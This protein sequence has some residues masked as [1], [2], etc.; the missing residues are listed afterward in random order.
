MLRIVAL[1]EE[2]CDIYN[3]NVF[4]K[5]SVMCTP[6]W[7]NFRSVSINRYQTVLYNENKTHIYNTVQAVQFRDFY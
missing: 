4:F 6:F 3:W 1:R 5:S 7:L 2:Y